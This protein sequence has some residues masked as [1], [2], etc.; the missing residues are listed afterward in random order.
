MVSHCLY[1]S[2]LSIDKTINL[3]LHYLSGMGKESGQT[4]METITKVIL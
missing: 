2:F 4:Q 3:N 1:L